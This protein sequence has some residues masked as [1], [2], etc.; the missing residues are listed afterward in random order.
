MLRVYHQM[1]QAKHHPSFAA[2]KSQYRSSCFCFGKEEWYG[3]ARKPYHTVEYLIGH[4][5]KKER[6]KCTT[7]MLLLLMAM[8][9]V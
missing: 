2:A 3:G 1:G 7:L 9:L 8:A 6:V 4:Y 5:S